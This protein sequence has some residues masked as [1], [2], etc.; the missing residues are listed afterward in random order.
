MGLNG[1]FFE[2]F[3]HPII[4]APFWATSGRVITLQAMFITALS[5]TLCL[6]AVHFLNKY[7]P[8]LMGKP[9]RQI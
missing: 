5:I 4:A 7:I 2:F 9:R 1:L 8:Q 6:P 3:N